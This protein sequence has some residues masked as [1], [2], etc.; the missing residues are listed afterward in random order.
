MVLTKRLG[1]G[2]NGYQ[3]PTTPQGSRSFRRKRSV[4]KRVEEDPMCAFELLAT[5]AGKLLLEKENSPAPVNTTGG[6]TLKPAFPKENVKEEQQ[7]ELKLHKTGSC[8]QGDCNTSTQ[9]SKNGSQR[10]TKVG[11]LSECQHASNMVGA[12]PRSIVIKSGPSKKVSSSEGSMFNKNKREFANSPSPDQGK[13]NSERHS[14]VAAVSQ[15]GKVEDGI[16]TPPQFEDQKI[17]NGNHEGVVGLYSSE[18]QMDV[19]VKP[20]LVRSVEVPVH[21]DPMSH[22]SSF[23]KCKSDTEFSVDRSNDGK[24]SGC[25][26]P[27]STTS[28]YFRTQRIGDRR[29]RKFLGSKFWKVGS[30]YL[31]DGEF[32]NSDE[33][34]KSVFYNRKMC[35]MRRRT[36]KS[37]FKR[38][39]LFERGSILTSDSP[40]SCEGISRSPQMGIKEEASSS[41][42]RAYGG[43]GTSSSIAGQRISFE[44]EEEYPVKLSIKSF[45]VPELFIEI[46]ETATVGSLKRTV[47]DAV[48]AI[49]GGGLRIGVVLQGKKVRDDN[50]TLLQAGISHSGELDGLGFTLEPNS[51]EAPQQLTTKTEGRQ[52][53]SICDAPEPLKRLP[54]IP[55][56]DP[57]IIETPT[58]PPPLTT[59]GSCVESDQHADPSPPDATA[60]MENNT[61]SSKALVVL[62]AMNAEALDIVPKSR[63]SEAGQRRIRRPFSVS[64]VEALVQAVEKLGTGR[65]RDVKLRA[66]DNANH[67]TYVDLK[68]SKHLASRTLNSLFLIPTHP[69]P[70]EHGRNH[71]LVGV[72]AGIFR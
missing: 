67:R 68:V 9:A 32:S 2:F 57:A 13:L 40:I 35:Y 44:S 54:A 22:I 48:S 45:K 47:M 43:N 24:S 3:V 5:V 16:S 1:Y 60:S 33:D 62:P 14:P 72:P 26:K 41:F 70:P 59:S 15:Q 52:F 11:R 55:A 61:P 53:L 27:Y 23:P 10:I 28:K 58:K 64:E 19:D 37:S 63:R 4:R 25:T 17:T 38:R 20:P 36:Q 71:V 30:T 8:D 31:K 18:D 39:K 34:V 49:L 6:G 29:I 56:S 46:P 12:R 66:F 69:Y 50:K 21:G 65:W 51:S 7:D 42:S